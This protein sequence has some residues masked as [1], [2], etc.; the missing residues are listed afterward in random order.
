MQH[1][2]RTPAWQG[3][4]CASQPVLGGRYYRRIVGRGNHPSAYAD[5]VPIVRRSIDAPARTRARPRGRPMPLPDVPTG[6]ASSR[7]PA[8]RR[9]VEL[10]SYQP[11]RDRIGGAPGALD[12]RVDRRPGRAPSRSA[13]RLASAA[14]VAA[15]VAPPARRRR[16]ETAVRRARPAPFRRA[17]RLRGSACGNLLRTANGWNRVSRTLRGPVHPPTAP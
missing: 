4:P 8:R 5:A 14:G 10:Q 17:S 13:A 7:R 1:A 12:Q 9:V 11:G 2:A 15:R 3:A 16:A 6:A